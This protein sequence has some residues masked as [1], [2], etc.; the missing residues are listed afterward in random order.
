MKRYLILISSKILTRARARV[1]GL[2]FYELKHFSCSQIQQHLPGVVVDV[3][4]TSQST[5]P[6]RLAFCGDRGCRPLD[7]PMDVGGDGKPPAVS[8]SAGP[9]RNPYSTY[10]SSGDCGNSATSPA[11]PS[12]PLGDAGREGVR[13]GLDWTVTVAWLVIL[14]EGRKI[15]YPLMAEGF[16]N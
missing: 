16:F 15:H 7:S 11:R 1:D 6:S 8:F 9:T 4:R 3:L 2:V 5:R 14:G 12:S 13:G 10:S